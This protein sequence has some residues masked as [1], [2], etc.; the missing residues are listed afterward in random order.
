MDSLDAKTLADLVL[1]QKFISHVGT[2]ENHL[3]VTKPLN[4]RNIPNPFQENTTL[5][6]FLSEGGQVH[7][8]VFNFVGVEIL[9]LEKEWLDQGFHTI[10]LD[11]GNLQKGLYI[12][13]LTSGSFSGSVIMAK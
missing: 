9:S 2:E 8:S 6:F 7:L 4:L 1:S 10:S 3:P 13:Y 5:E 12:G 11:L